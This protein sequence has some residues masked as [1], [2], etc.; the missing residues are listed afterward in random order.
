MKYS[1]FMSA[2]VEIY[3]A[4]K[5]EVLEQLTVR[6]VKKRFSE[7]DLEK[8]LMQL[9]LN[10]S[11]KFKTPPDPAEFEELFFRHD[12]CL[13]AEALKWWVELNRKSNSY[14]DC[15]I[16]DLRVQTAIEAMGGWVMFCSRIVRDE[17]GRDLDNWNR[18]Q[19]TD[20]YKLY[21]KYPPETEIKVL[22]G[23]TDN[24]SKIIIIGD[25]EKC[26]LVMEEKKHGGM[27]VIEDMVAGMRIC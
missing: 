19:F 14:R 27:K 26:R 25:E 3:G 21:S 12:D 5:S 20:L 23:I 17:K 24:R 9:T 10:K 8:I 11:A 15:I 22:H 7:N 4:Y 6:Y 13:E 18:K 2:V 16:S 1:E